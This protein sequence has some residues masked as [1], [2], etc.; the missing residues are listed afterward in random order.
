MRGRAGTSAEAMPMDK[1][2]R[3]L[4]PLLYGSVYGVCGFELLYGDAGEEED[5]EDCEL[6]PSGLGVKGVCGLEA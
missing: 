5:D 2:V 6:M 4:S 1:P 3:S